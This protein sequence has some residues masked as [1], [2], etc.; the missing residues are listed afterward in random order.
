MRPGRCVEFSWLVGRVNPPTG[1]LDEPPERSGKQGNVMAP[2]LEHTGTPGIYRQHVADVREL[3]GELR[4]TGA[5]TSA[6]KKLRAALSDVRDRG[7]GRPPTLE[8]GPGR[9]HS[10]AGK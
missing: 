5:T 9:S 10:R 7:R 6:I 3:F 1:T 4:R 2:R 8:P